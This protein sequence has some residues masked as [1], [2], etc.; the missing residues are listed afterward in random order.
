[1]KESK[2]PVMVRGKW[3]D[4]NNPMSPIHFNARP[5]STFNL[6]EGYIFKSVMV[7]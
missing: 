2:D 6:K 3:F 4:F 5:A 1:M 7:K